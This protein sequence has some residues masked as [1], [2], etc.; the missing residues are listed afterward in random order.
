MTRAV[1]AVPWIAVRAFC[2]FISRRWCEI[3]DLAAAGVARG[4]VRYDRQDGYG[5]LI[6]VSCLWGWVGVWY[7]G[8]G[9]YRFGCEITN[10]IFF[11]VYREAGPIRPLFISIICEKKNDLNK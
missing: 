8:L 1:A 6:W 4:C 10:I 9:D 11:R 5:N 2:I 7:V 3:I